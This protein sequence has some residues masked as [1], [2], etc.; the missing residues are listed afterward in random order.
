M[1]QLKVLS[2][3]ALCTREQDVPKLKSN[4]FQTF[5]VHHDALG[6]IGTAKIVHVEV[7][8]MDDEVFYADM[9]TGSLYDMDTMRCLTGP[10]ELRQ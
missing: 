3:E 7:E 9:N 10:L 2:G 6:N 8:S 5:D 4:H 1:I